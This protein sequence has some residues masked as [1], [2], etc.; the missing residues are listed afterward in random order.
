MQNGQMTAENTQPD[1]VVKTLSYLYGK[2]AF[3]YLANFRDTDAYKKLKS[4]TIDKMTHMELICLA[5][6]S[7]DISNISPTRFFEALY[8]LSNAL[9]KNILDGLMI[10]MY[11]LEF[12]QRETKP[13]EERIFKN[14]NKL[15]EALSEKFLKRGT[16][17]KPCITFI[18]LAGVNLENADL[19]GV[20]L[21]NTNLELTNLENANLEDI[22]LFSPGAQDD[23][24]C[25][26]AELDAVQ[27]QIEKIFKRDTN[28]ELS[29]EEK[30]KIAAAN[31]IIDNLDS[32]CPREKALALIDTALG[33]PTLFKT[34]L[35][36]NSGYFMR[37]FALMKPMVTESQ[38][39]LLGA[40]DRIQN[41]LTYMT[42]SHGVSTLTP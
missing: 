21:Y 26:K 37:L 2:E 39:L 1:H 19:R 25:L 24:N 5:L 28:N 33:H 7:D 34:K 4:M 29:T 41:S 15:V 16:L 11:S 31:N 20:G 35:P 14:P 32:N 40:R 13:L 12:H 38:Q 8:E 36:E 6:T 27:Q 9:D 23:V 18:N 42:P 17:S 10:M 30:F 22:K 3:Q